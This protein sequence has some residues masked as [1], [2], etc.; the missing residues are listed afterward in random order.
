MARSVL[1]LP[2]NTLQNSPLLK[3]LTH[4]N[5]GLERAQPRDTWLVYHLSGTP[6]RYQ[7]FCPFLPHPA[8]RNRCMVSPMVIVCV[9]VIWLL[10]GCDGIGDL[11]WS[12]VRSGCASAG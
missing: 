4:Q 9:L 10:N 6:K 1:S 12:V 8:V 3:V 2:S 7:L 5:N 11:V